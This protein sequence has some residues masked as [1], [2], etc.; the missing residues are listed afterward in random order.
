MAALSDRPLRR[1]LIP[2]EQIAGF[3]RWR[4]AAV[5]GEPDE[6]HEPAD[7]IDQPALEAARQLGFEEGIETGRAQALAEAAQQLDDYIAGQGRAAAERFAALFDAA[8]ARLLE[9]EQTMARGTLEIAC[10]LARRVLRHEIATN[11]NT[12][13][14]VVREALSMLLGDG[15]SARVRLSH[16]DFDMLDEPLRAE[17]SSRSVTVVADVAIQPGDC[18]IESAGAVVDGGAASRWTRA[19]ASLGLLL[20]WSTRASDRAGVGGERATD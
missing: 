2:G 15:K 6:P 19:V 12:L 17:F 7:T 13:E 20:P 3:Q 8:E 18:L 9:A 5:D 10:A 4:F 14:P 16:A 11:P 1:A